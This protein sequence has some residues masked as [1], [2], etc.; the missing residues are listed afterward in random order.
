MGWIKEGRFIILYQGPSVDAFANQLVVDTDTWDISM[1]TRFEYDSSTGRTPALA[2]IDER[3]YL[4]VYQGDNNDGW[5][6][7][8]WLD[9]PILP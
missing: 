2:R 4:S 8:L 9:A 3:H 7:I 5:A 6:V 1:A